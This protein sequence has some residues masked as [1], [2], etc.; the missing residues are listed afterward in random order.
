VKRFEFILEHRSEHTITIMARVLRVSRSGYQHWFD[1]RGTLSKQAH[2]RLFRDELILEAFQKS[3]QRSG[4]VRL[5]RDL[6]EQGYACD[7]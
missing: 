1:R 6:E 7:I 3:K 4:V 5:W 2:Q